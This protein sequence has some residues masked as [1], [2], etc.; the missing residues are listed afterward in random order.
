MILSCTT[1]AL[2]GRRRDEI[3]ETFRYA[4]S[5]GFKYW[6]MAGPFSFEPGLIQ[7]LDVAK[8]QRCAREAG[9]V[10]CTEIWTPP[11][12]TDSE[13]WAQTGAEHIAMCARV[14]VQIRCPVIVQTGGPRREGGLPKTI[15]G[16][17]KLLRRVKD[18]PIKV[19]LEP[20]VNSQILYPEDYAEIFRRLSTPQLGV[21][22]D[23]GHFHSAGV[24]WK[25]IIRAWRDRIYNVHVKDHVGRQS[26]PIG[27]GEID[28]AGLVRELDGIGYA[29][30]L[31]IEME[32]TDPENLHRYVPE[33]YQHM[34]RMLNATGSAASTT[35]PARRQ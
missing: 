12:P 24:D 33:A 3:E 5:A 32:V 9:L 35:E 15:A 28:L 10:G 17:E 31:A 14:A 22:V 7:W 27:R 29:G 2:R 6:G 34:K 4:A 13:E 30:A 18:L 23:I 16:I 20:H 26:V 1:C 25:A 8:L 11:I 19:A 21:T